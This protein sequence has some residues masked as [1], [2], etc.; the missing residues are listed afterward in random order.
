MK[1]TTWLILCCGIALR[2]TAWSQRSSLWLDEVALALNVNGRSLWE[3][4]AV[5]LDYGQAAPRGFLLLQWCITN[6][7]GRSDLA[8][9]LL[10]C[11]AGV[12]SLFLFRRVALR[13]LS[14]TGAAV[15]LLYFAFG[16][17]FIFFSADAK[18]YGLDLTLSLLMLELSF[19]FRES[20]Y[21]AAKRFP[22]AAAGCFS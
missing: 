4:L 14:A 12:A 20:S 22:L 15:A 13:V 3:L 19:D 5:P 18:P 8:F 7:V 2:L 9:R 1:A 6:T 21:D 11:I 17:W 10:P 16:F